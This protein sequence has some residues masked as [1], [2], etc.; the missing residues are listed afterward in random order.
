MSKIVKIKGGIG[1]QLFQY[2]F[3]KFLSSRGF[4]VELDV[5]WYHQV[6]ISNSLTKRELY[7]NK[8]LNNF[9]KISN[10]KTSIK[11]KILSYKSE[12]LQSYFAKKDIFYTDFFD[13]YWQDIF[14]AKFL[15][16]DDLNYEII[17]KKTD[18]PE[19]Y[20]VMHTRYGDF[21]RSKVHCCLPDSYYLDNIE[22]FKDHPIYVLTDDYDHTNKILKKINKKT[23]I[24]KTNEIDAFKIIYNA[25]GG[26][27]SNSTFC[28]WPIFLSKNFNWIMPKSWL[29][30]RDIYK[31]NVY[32]K[33]T[34]VKNDVQQ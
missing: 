14:Y 11:D 33:G 18:L 21:K 24:L 27:S 26:I 32:I 34:K 10:H 17:N 31:S 2:A 12:K 4:E 19:K 9:P 29:K 8:I 15:N 3:F 1:N 22:S 5:S 25:H 13:G 6:K 28:W 30:N 16:L 7:L 23:Q 20:Y